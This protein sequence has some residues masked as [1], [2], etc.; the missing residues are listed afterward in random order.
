[1]TAERSSHS[2]SSNGSIAIGPASVKKRGNV[3]PGAEAGALLFARGFSTSPSTSGT[4]DDPT[5]LYRLL[6]AT[7][8]LEGSAFFH[9]SSTDD[10]HVPPPEAT[11]EA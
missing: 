10:D 2:T 3:S 8:G 5:A 1:M 4:A 9:V 7:R 6:A 11:V